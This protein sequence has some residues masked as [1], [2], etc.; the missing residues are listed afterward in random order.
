MSNTPHQLAADFPE[1]ADKI[2]ELKS[3]DSHF[4]H[5]AGQY[6]ALN[7]EVH[8]AET[9]MHPMEDLAL[10]ELRKKRMLLKDELYKMLTQ[11]A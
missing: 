11:P 6:D 9:D 4:A 10:S 2:M 1:L 5:L 7:E 3:S 8:Q